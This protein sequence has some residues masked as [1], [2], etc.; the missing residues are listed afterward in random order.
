R[1]IPEVLIQHNKSTDFDTIFVIGQGLYVLFV[2]I[3][4][5]KT[6]PIF[7]FDSC[8]NAIEKGTLK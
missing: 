6:W 1:S 5:Y 3:Q 4:K 2:V 7:Y 8:N